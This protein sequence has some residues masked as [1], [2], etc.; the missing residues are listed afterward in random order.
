MPSLAGK[1]ALVTGS[2]Q[3]IGAALA[4]AMAA[5]GAKVVVSDVQDCADTVRQIA[6]RGGEAIGVPA[7]VTD[8]KS[9][10]E[11]PGEL[12]HAIVRDLR[13]IRF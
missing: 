2:S 4:M 13:T 6:E 10:Q 11:N 3:G 12:V 5:E 7:D 8:N 9:L 1:V